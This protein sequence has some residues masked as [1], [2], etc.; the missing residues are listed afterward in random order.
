MYPESV[1]TVRLLSMG[2]LLNL[3]IGLALGGGV[4]RGYAHIGVLKALKENNIEPDVISGTSIGSI[5]GA[6][7]AK[8]KSID[9]LKKIAF[10]FSHKDHFKL[11]DFSIRTGFIS[12]NKLMKYVSDI[13]EAENHLQFS[14]LCLPL[15]IIASDINTGKE[16]IYSKGD[17]LKA[18]R[19]SIAIPVIFSPVSVGKLLLVDGGITSPVPLQ[20]LEESGCDII[21]G[22]NLLKGKYKET[23]FNIFD[24]ALKSIIVMQQQL[25]K[26][27]QTILKS[28]SSIMISPKLDYSWSD[29]RHPQAMINA[30]EKETKKHIQNIKELIDSR[31]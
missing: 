22:V 26:N 3:K 6:L 31:T 11:V 2:G 16:H 27:S 4:A 7:Y 18:I 1:L 17:V 10:E 20:C 5:I 28:A 24:V 30:G 14:Q 25:T 13:L 15:K 23:T 29:F 8:Y 21:I 19:A 12:G 9:K